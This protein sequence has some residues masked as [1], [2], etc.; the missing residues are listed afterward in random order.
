MIIYG[1]N[2]SQRAA[3][4]EEHLKCTSCNNGPVVLATFARYAHIYWI[5]LFSIG[6]STYSKCSHCHLELEE[7]EMPTD[8][9]ESVVR[10]K[11]EASIPFWHFS[12]LILI[13]LGIIFASAYSVVDDDRMAEQIQAPV[14]GDKYKIKYD[15]E[16]YSLWLVTDV[17]DDSITII[18]HAYVVN[19]YS[20]LDES[21]FI[22]TADYEKDTY[23]LF[24]REALLDML[25]DG[26]IRDVV[27]R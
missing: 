9:Q 8:F 1:T 5:P 27:R 10:Q 16:E 15:T 19:Q 18:P 13:I 26:D 23:M 21:P 12:G 6:K 4:A 11:G 25:N 7:K 24:T 14:V 20:G 22:G 3:S 17:A 2:S